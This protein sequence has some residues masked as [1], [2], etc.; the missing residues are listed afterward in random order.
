VHLSKH[1]PN[2][3]V[4]MAISYGIYLLFIF[5]EGIGGGVLDAR[6]GTKSSVA[7]LLFVLHQRVRV[8]EPTSESTLCI[9][10][11]IDGITALA[12]I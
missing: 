1:S 2:L 12:H 8:S 9:A 5:G 7:S 4:A 10:Y 11:P 6:A 3:L